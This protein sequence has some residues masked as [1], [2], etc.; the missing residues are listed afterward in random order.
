M[1][2]IFH[3][4]SSIVWAGFRKVY[5]LFPYATTAEQGIPHDIRTMHELWGVGTYRKQN[6][7]CATA[8][9][10]DLINSLDS[11]E[12]KEALLES[13]NRLTSAYNKL[14]ATYHENKISNPNNTLVLG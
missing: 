6:R 10:L 2:H 4:F 13:H 9:L 1:I 8:C 11:S 7:Y 3:D 5:Y 14:S 12:E